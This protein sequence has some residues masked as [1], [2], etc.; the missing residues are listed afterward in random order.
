LTQTGVVM[1]TPAYMPIEQHL[2]Q[3]ADPRCDQYSFAVALFEALYGQRPFAGSNTAELCAA[4]KRAAP[5]IPSTPLAVPRRVRRAILRGLCAQPKDR[6]PS[7]L[8]LVR[9]LTPPVRSRRTWMLGGVAGLTIGAAAVALVDPPER[10]CSAFAT[11]AAAVY[12]GTDKRKILSAFTATGTPYA[13]SSFDAT[14]RAL[15]VFS[16]QWVEG[17]NGACLATDR[18]EQS[19]RMLDLRMSCLDRGLRRLGATVQAL[20]TADA[21]T[22]ERAPKLTEQ[23]PDLAPCAN[24]ETVSQGVFIPETQAQRADAQELLPLLDKAT[25]L[26]WQDDLDGVRAALEPFDT[27]LRSSTHPRVRAQHQLVEGR[28]LRGGERMALLR[29]ALDVALEYNLN[30]VAAKACISAGYAH[31]DQLEGDRATSMFEQALA[32]G[33]ATGQP[34]PVLDALAGLSKVAAGQLQ[35][36]VAIEYAREAVGVSGDAQ[37]F[38]VRASA[39]VLLSELLHKRDGAEAGLEQLELAHALLVREVGEHHPAHEEYLQEVLMRANERGDSEKAVETSATLLAL[40][41]RNRGPGST[42]E[43]VTLANLSSAHKAL[44][45]HEEALESLS[46]SDE[47]F[48]KK[49]GDDYAHRAGLLN[50]RGALQITMGRLDDARTTML[51]ARRL[52]EARLGPGTEATAVTQLN[53]SEI[54]RL[55][56]NLQAARVHAQEARGH[57]SKRL[58]P[59]HVRTARAHV[60]IAEVEL[61]ADEPERAA[62]SMAHALTIGTPRPA[63]EMLWSVLKAEATLRSSTQTDTERH[64]AQAAVDA[65]RNT[66]AEASSYGTKTRDALIRIEA[67]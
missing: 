15:D 36:D 8:A 17:A 27:R 40:L 47:I 49:L 60:A 61:A 50:N 31:N 52:F 51:L 14:T 46:Q 3:P 34:I 42:R 59:D 30:D 44:G 21:R 18:G 6:F 57:F 32:L 64:E 54:E 63:E 28:T 58:G 20:T 13:Q 41:R 1:G 16:K 43:A 38:G 7:M 10:P 23:L 66:A 37:T 48:R 5:A 9:A 29:G 55:A 33:R 65:A 53:L 39:L 19:G 25:V 24:T 12:S 35:Y 2:G 11:R 22:V 67:L 56:G 4:I 26:V 45:L 62:V